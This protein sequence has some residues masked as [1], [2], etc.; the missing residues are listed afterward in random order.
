MMRFF[1]FLIFLFSTLSSIANQF[2]QLVNAPVQEVEVVNLNQLKS[3]QLAIAM[4]FAK[5][6]ILNPEQQ[7]YFDEQVVVKIEL[8]YT[9]YRTSPTFDQKQLNFNRLTELN[10]LLPD[11]FKNP[12]WDYALVSQTNGNS[13]EECNPMFHGFIFTFR[14]NSSPTTLAEESS[15]LQKVIDNLI[16]QNNNDPN[17]KLSYELKTRWD[18]KIGYVHDTIW[19][20]NDIKEVPVPD[21][22]YDHSLYKDSTV[23]NVFERNQSWQNFAVVTDVTGSMSPYIAQVFVWLKQQTE[24]NNAKYFVFFNDGDNKESRK[25]KPLETGG[26]YGTTNK[27]L[28]T[29]MQTAA[30]CMQNGSGGGERQEND[31]EAILLAQQEYED[32]KEIILVADN[33]ESMRDYKHIDE[34]KKPVR[35]IA[36]GVKNRINIEYLDLARITK[37]SVHT[38]T[39]DVYDLDKVKQGQQISIAGERYIFDNGR[40]HFLY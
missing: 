1:S 40:F 12:L 11:L 5:E 8:V 26:V 7:K 30:R 15:Y 35:I 4:P 6:I 16:K 32:A 9:K 33:F 14:P 36:C 17:D 2:Q 20:V 34:I 24:N 3:N 39:E 31:V 28:E 23:L 18:T 29:V 19:K 13:R 21:I 25:K 38:K 22:F 27:G 37:G 10:K